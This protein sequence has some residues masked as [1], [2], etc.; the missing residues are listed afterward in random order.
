MSTRSQIGIF[1][2]RNGKLDYVFCHWD[3]NVK[4]VGQRLL[5]FYDTEQKVRE[6]LANGDIESLG[7]SVE[8]TGFYGDPSSLQK[9]EADSLE[10]A[11]LSMLEFPIEFVYIFDVESRS[12]V[13]AS[14]ESKEVDGGLEVKP[15]PRDSSSG[16]W[17]DYVS[18]KDAEADI[19]EMLDTL[20]GVYALKN[21]TLYSTLQGVF[22]A[23]KSIDIS[24]R[25]NEV[26]CHCKNR[27]NIKM[28]SLSGYE[29]CK[30][31]DA[32][33]FNSEKA[34]IGSAPVSE[35]RLKLCSSC[36][37]KSHRT[38]SFGRMVS[39][40]TIVSKDDLAHALCGIIECNA[41]PRD[42]I[43]NWSVFVNGDLTSFP[44]WCYTD[45]RTGKVM[46]GI[47]KLKS[48]I[49]NIDE[50]DIDDAISMENIDDSFTRNGIREI[51]GDIVDGYLF[52]GNSYDA[53]FASPKGMEL[54]L[55]TTERDLYNL[56]QR[57]DE[58]YADIQEDLTE[59]LTDGICRN[60]GIGSWQDDLDVIDSLADE[61]ICLRK[62]RR[63]MKRSRS[64]R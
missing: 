20:G 55:P 41:F 8:V 57:A 42:L 31:A 9:T 10:H 64:R 19:R 53:G 13:Y 63:S 1:D 30:L 14:D 18:R 11:A 58:F 12:W 6:L 43:G 27:K 23:I 59:R 45:D 4:W 39:N 25:G 24:K 34:I 49:F 2:S 32:M 56:L 35:R 29:V 51:A 16:A 17:D 54:E 38:E 22:Q 52:D 44:V 33:A 28:S 61:R 15:I 60:L 46:F 62:E 40:D 36:R 48:Y 21:D 5:G 7:N 47:S 50:D 37:N 3:G 26:V